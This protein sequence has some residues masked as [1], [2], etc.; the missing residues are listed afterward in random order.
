M[1]YVGFMKNFLLSDSSEQMAVRDISAP[2]PKNVWFLLS[3]DDLG[4]VHE[5]FSSLR[6]ERADSC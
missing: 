6:F 4:R 5:K 2:E 3:R 1:M